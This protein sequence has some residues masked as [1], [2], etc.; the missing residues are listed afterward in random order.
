MHELSI[1]MSILDFAEEEAA[2]RGAAVEAVHVRMGAMSGVVKQALISAYDLARE[3]TTLSDCR[4]VIE[5]VPVVIYCRVCQIER[6]ALSAQ[7][8]SC[9]ICHVP[10][11]D[12]VSGKE[13]EVIG[14]E[15]A[16]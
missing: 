14:L 7:Q 4:L 10:S 11:S 5:D 3:S 13:L 15:V 9:P 2:R 16:A 6:A 1:A 12:F 8:L